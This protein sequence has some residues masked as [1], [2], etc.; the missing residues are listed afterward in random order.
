M[1]V[2]YKA[3]DTAVERPVALKFLAQ[4]LV[5]NQEVRKRFLREARTAAA[6][7]H[8]NICTVHEI[9]ESDGCTFISM[10]YLEGHELAA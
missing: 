7:S 1:G 8:P 10:S 4:H 2:A 3:V 6:L 9:G 5:S